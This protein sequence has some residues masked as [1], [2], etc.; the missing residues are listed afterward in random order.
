MWLHF[1]D[2]GAVQT[3]VIVG[4]LD[5]ARQAAR[6]LAAE[7]EVSGVPAGAE[8]ALAEFRDAAR[9]V[10]AAESLEEAIGATSRMAQSC[11]D[12]HTAQ[13]TGPVFQDVS[14]E[15]DFGDVGHMV[16]HIW[17]ADRLWEGLVQPTSNG[18]EAGARVLAEHEIPM[19]ELPAGTSSLAVDLKS[20]GL[21]AMSDR[22][23]EARSARYEQIVATCAACHIRSAGG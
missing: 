1:Q 16:E 17:A 6:R 11:G 20:L 14:E 23:P 5:R 2:A 9:A 4:D 8:I 7:G 12:C 15:P 22:T 19:M 21:D 13:R 10:A 3:S 18:W